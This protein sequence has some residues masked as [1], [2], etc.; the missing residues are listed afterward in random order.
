MMGA[1]RMAGHEKPPLS[2]AGAAVPFR[3]GLL[4]EEH[5]WIWATLSPPPEL[6]LKM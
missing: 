2:T 5:G 4:R 1:H 3:S 6:I